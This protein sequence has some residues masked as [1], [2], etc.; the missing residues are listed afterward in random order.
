MALCVSKSEI[1]TTKE[2]IG[3][4]AQTKYIRI[5]IYFVRACDLV[6]DPS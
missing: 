2:I 1:P 3:F 6:D 5:F 4:L